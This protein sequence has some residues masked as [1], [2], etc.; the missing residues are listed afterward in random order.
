MD[1][2]ILDVPAGLDWAIFRRVAA[3]TFYLVLRR[4]F[5]LTASPQPSDSTPFPGAALTLS[6]DRDC[7]RPAGVCGS[8]CRP[9]RARRRCVAASRRA[10][11]CW[12]P[13]RC[14]LC[15]IHV[16]TP[17]FVDWYYSHRAARRQCP[18]AA[19]RIMYCWTPARCAVC[20]PQREHFRRHYCRGDGGNFRRTAAQ[21]AG[22]SIWIPS[23]GWI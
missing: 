1:S 5:V 21:P 4:F 9:G 12:A 11:F 16:G 7:Y 3:H 2:E 13:A 23:A 15:S 6:S 22:L 8:C 14:A 10:A 18:A 20:C 19:R 17:R